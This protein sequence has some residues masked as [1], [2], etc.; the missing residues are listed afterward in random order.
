MRPWRAFE[1]PFLIAHA[2]HDRLGRSLH[3]IITRLSHRNP[4]DQP[5]LVGDP[6]HPLTPPAFTSPSLLSSHGKLSLG[7]FGIWC[8]FRS[9]ILQF[10][11][12]ES[13]PKKRIPASTPWSLP[14]P[15]GLFP[16]ENSRHRQL[17]NQVENTFP[18]NTL[19]KLCRNVRL[20]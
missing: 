1:G 10:F 20:L 6:I 7:G 2:N 18:T 17:C 11:Q 4:R 16:S 5:R 9:C 19:V 15:R 13:G 3:R 12:P 8:W 14:A